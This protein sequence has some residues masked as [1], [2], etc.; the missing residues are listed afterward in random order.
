MLSNIMNVANTECAK[1]GWSCDIGVL[2]VLCDCD[3]EPSYVF[4]GSKIFFVGISWVQNIFSW[5]FCGSQ[6][7]SRGYFVVFSC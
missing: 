6:I 1:F 7:F 2:C 3:I 5:V 4:H